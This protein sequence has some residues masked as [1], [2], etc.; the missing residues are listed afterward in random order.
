MPIAVRPIAR[1]GHVA[2]RFH[3]ALVAAI[4]AVAREVGEPRVALSGGCFQNRTLVERAS[5]AL[6]A[7]GFEVLL[8]RH[9][10]PNDGGIA[11]GQAVV[12]ARRLQEA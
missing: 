6:E 4:V 2:S 11:L 3:A 5:R 10:P 7:R 1:S 8:H 12:A 9:V